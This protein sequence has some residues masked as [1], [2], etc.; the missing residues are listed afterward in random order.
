MILEV[1]HEEKASVAE[2]PLEAMR[3]ACE[4]SVPH[5]VNL[6]WGDSWADAKG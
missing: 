2:L 3:E 5:E 6:A 1:P 4:L